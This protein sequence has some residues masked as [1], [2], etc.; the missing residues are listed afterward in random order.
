[1]DWC[2]LRAVVQIP[3]SSRVMNPM[4][5]G[6]LQLLFG[7]LMVFLSTRSR[8]LE[9]PATSFQACGADCNQGPKGFWHVFIRCLMWFVEHFNDATLL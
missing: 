1:M 6:S 8:S 5:N 7:E 9:C 2:F 3:R 4:E